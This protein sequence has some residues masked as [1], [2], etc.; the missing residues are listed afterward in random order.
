MDV[1][2]VLYQFVVIHVKQNRFAYEYKTV[3]NR[4][5]EGCRA[6]EWRCNNGECINADFLC[7]GSKDC[8]DKSDEGSVCATGKFKFEIW[9]KLTHSHSINLSDLHVSDLWH[10]F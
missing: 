9:N 5:N 3:E 7:D 10:L 2:I 1:I 4:P 8:T 6:G